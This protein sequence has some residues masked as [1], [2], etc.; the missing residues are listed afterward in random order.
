[1]SSLQSDKLLKLLGQLV[2]QYRT[3]DESQAV[4]ARRLGISR[5]TLGA[6]EEGKGGKL[7]TL[8]EA[9]VIFELDGVFADLANELIGEV[10]GDRPRRRKAKKQ[11]LLDNDF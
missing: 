9:L 6:L 2:R 7:G 4:F 10:S 1:M 3:Q 8:C 5:K 11:V